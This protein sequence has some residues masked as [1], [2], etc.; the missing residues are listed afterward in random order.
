[1]IDYRVVNTSKGECEVIRARRTSLG[2]TFQDHWVR[3][4]KCHINAIL[5]HDGKIKGVGSTKLENQRL[6]NEAVRVFNEIQEATKNK[7]SHIKRIK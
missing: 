6:I 3:N 5:T 1:M 4:E 7:V 2:F